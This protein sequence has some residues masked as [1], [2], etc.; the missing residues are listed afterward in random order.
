[1][2][3]CGKVEKHSLDRIYDLFNERAIPAVIESKT[4]KQLHYNSLELNRA[5]NAIRKSMKKGLLLYKAEV[6]E[7]GCRPTRFYFFSFVKYSVSEERL[8]LV[9]KIVDCHDLKTRW[10]INPA[11]QFKADL[12]LVEEKFKWIK[13]IV[14]V[15]YKQV[16]TTFR[17]DM[18]MYREVGKELVDTK[19]MIALK[20][21]L[22]AIRK[23][24][25]KFDHTWFDP[26]PLRQ[27]SG[28]DWRP[29]VMVC[30]PSGTG[31]T[32]IPFTLCQDKLPFLYLLDCTPEE[33]TPGDQKIY[34]AFH[35]I[36]KKFEELCQ[37]DMVK[38]Q[39]ELK[40]N[41]Y[42][43]DALDEDFFDTVRRKNIQLESAGFLCAL[44]KKVIRMW[45]M[46]KSSKVADNFDWIEGQ[47][48]VDFANLHFKA[49][50]LKAASSKLNMLE[51]D[52]LPKPVIFMD[53]CDTLNGRKWMF[54]FKRNLIRSIDLIP[55]IM[56]TDTKLDYKVNTSV[57][58]CHHYRK[59]GDH[60]KSGLVVHE[61]PVF[62]HEVVQESL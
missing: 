55:V 29:F 41:Y 14:Q 50:D 28:I 1:M 35:E 10:D 2:L 22:T 52:D 58:G 23:I 56:G 7:I 53:E 11:K 42:P 6:K 16:A 12:K 62:P 33:N 43:P 36:S 19:E 54:T 46:H 51:K 44:Y 45:S 30:S 47:L 48:N 61:L 32:Q 60:D 24:G 17:R 57:A 34:H 31:K 37:R 9:M 5:F 27:D 13:E 38:C 18:Q 15:L 59:H 49:L 8:R 3:P 21:I 26:Y 20:G 4:L 25:F 39:T 40:R